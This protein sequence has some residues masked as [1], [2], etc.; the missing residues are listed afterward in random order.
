MKV[1]ANRT[2]YVVRGAFV[3]NERTKM[4]EYI[5]YLDFTSR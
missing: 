3:W 5:T 4:R 2:D 1:I